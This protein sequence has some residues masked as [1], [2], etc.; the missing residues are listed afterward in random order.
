MSNLLDALKLLVDNGLPTGAIGPIVNDI[1]AANALDD[2]DDAKV[3][4]LLS[5]HPS[6]YSLDI[7]TGY[8]DCT[9]EIDGE[10]WLVLTEDEKEQRWDEVLD[11]YLDDGC[12]EGADSPYFDREMWKRDA[13]MDGA[14]HTLG[15]YDGAEYECEVCDNW[16]H[17]IRQN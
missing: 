16:Y 7:E 6:S 1:V 11:S 2:D 5:E 3:I 4:A 14:G 10:E 12:V 15:G 8:D 13:R 17:L 9:F